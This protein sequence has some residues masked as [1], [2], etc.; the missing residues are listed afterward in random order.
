MKPN[1]TIK[2]LWLF[3]GIA[4]LLISCAGEK[5]KLTGLTCEYLSAP[6][7]VDVDQPRFSWKIQSHERGVRQQAFRIIVSET[8]SGA[9]R[10]TGDCWD[11]GK[12]AADQTVNVAYEGI[13]L[14]SNRKYHWRVCIWTDSKD[15]F[16]SD[17]E[18]FHTG[19]LNPSDWLARWVTTPEEIVHESPVFRKEVTVEKKIRQA[20]AFVTACGFCEVYLNGGKVGDHVLD[21]GITDYRKTILYPTY[22]VTRMLRQGDN[23]IGVML[24]NG[25]WNMRKVQDRYSWGEERSFGNPCWI[26]QLHVTYS[27]GSEAV[28]VSDE[29]WKY[30]A[31]PV[32]FNNLYGGEDYDARKE[33]AGW[34]TPDFDDGHW[35]QAVQAE[36]PG[37]QLKSQ[38]MPPVR[39]TD[40]LIPVAETNPSPGVYLFDLGRNIAGWWRVQVKG[41]AGMTIR[42]RG[43]ETLNDSLFPKPLEPGDSLSAKFRYHALAWTD[44]TL[45]GDAVEVYEPH[46]FYTGFRYVEV[47]TGN[48]ENPGLL[49][50]EGRVVRSALGQTGMF[51]SS[52]TLL[53]QIHRAG[54]W[55]QMGNTFSYPTDCPHREKGAYNGDGQVIAETSMH[56]FQMAAFYTKWLNDMR[57]SQEENGR[58]PNTSPTLVGGMGGG[59]AWGSAYILIPWWMNHYYQDV[60]IMKAHYP[61]M[62]KYIHYLKALGT[63]DANPDEPFI[64]NDFDGYWYSLGEWCSPGR[65]D[66]PN[67]AVVNTFYYYYDTWLMAKIAAILG[68]EADAG[69]FSALADTVK[70]AFNEKFF[71]PDT[72]LYGG[73]EAY[74]TYQLIALVGGLVPEEHRQAVFNTIIQDLH[75]RDNHLN[76]GIIGT[77]YL[78]PVLV[79]GGQGNLALE[80][81]GKTTYPGY[82]YWLKNGSTTLL[83]EWSGAGSHNHQMFGSVSGFFYKYLAGIQ[84]PMEGH[85]SPG[86]RHIHLQPFVPDSLRSVRASVETVA[87][88]ILSDWKKEDGL[89]RYQVSIPA[90]TTGTVVIPVF[91]SR[92]AVL[93]ESGAR[94]WERGRFPGG[95]AGVTEVKEES[96]RLRIAIESGDYNFEID[97]RAE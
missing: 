61:T 38:L 74:Q 9:R 16:W 57:D 24:G 48:Q 83:E 18:V 1:L 15:P 96:G 79:D 56:D 65:S 42:I 68:E 29:S 27:D 49:K 40:T 69:Y 13:P 78:W 10:E 33:P 93:T 62:K 5:V 58:I 71:N 81:A 84:S 92:D 34:L 63:K 90:N 6:L 77:K 8:P 70:Q 60:R 66:C 59:V 88:T 46:F 39:V 86:Y 37:G 25:A 72:N 73:D 32:V 4:L 53:N 19:L 89:F 97:T 75:E 45:K 30:S 23:V 85:T 7:G 52:D 43:A 94:I 44:Y 55:S 95:V 22:D 21:P 76:T 82:G 47:T 11:S 20:Y 41:P 87:G 35:R 17:T 31:G 36:N 26:M 12:I 2:K 91:G 14:K 3:V 50:V 64:I 67:H 54:V 28:I 80:V 51:T